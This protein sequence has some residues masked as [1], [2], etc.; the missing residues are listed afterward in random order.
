VR[1]G[2]DELIADTDYTVTQDGVYTLISIPNIAADQLDADYSVIVTAGDSSCTL[3]LSAL[4]WAK[5]VLDNAEAMQKKL[6]SQKHLRN[7]L[8]KPKKNRQ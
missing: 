2:V 7:T 6:M 4:S 8:P 1:K 3:T 5:S